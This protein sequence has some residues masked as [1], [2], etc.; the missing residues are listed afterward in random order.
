MVTVNSFQRISI[1]SYARTSSSPLPKFPKMATWSLMNGTTW[2]S[3]TGLIRTAVVLGSS[4]MCFPKALLGQRDCT[5]APWI[6]RTRI[7][8][9][10][11]Y[12]QSEVVVISGQH[13]HQFKWL[14]YFSCPGWNHGSLSFSQMVN[15]QVAR[16]NFVYNAVQF[17]KNNSF[18]GLDLDWEYPGR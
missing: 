10:R 18:S 1:H 9:S 6:S 17:L 8:T 3:S 4:F 7:L 15:N 14:S 5:S 2:V 16:R 12:W 11:F 13:R